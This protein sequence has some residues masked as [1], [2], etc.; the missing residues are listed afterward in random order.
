ML[1][2]EVS[3]F[4]HGITHTLAFPSWATVC[5][6]C[7][8]IAGCFLDP[9]AWGS[10]PCRDFRDNFTGLG[11]WCV[12]ALQEPPWLL[13]PLPPPSLISL[14]WLA[15]FALVMPLS[16]LSHNNYAGI[17]SHYIS[18]G[19]GGFYT[20]GETLPLRGTV[21]LKLLPPAFTRNCSR[22]TSIRPLRVT[23]F[24]TWY[25]WFAALVIFSSH[26]LT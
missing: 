16:K 26:C 18:G 19:G 22:N 25:S 15:F 8:E 17:K 1:P 2:S 5:F 4:A 9:P 6:H 10:F 20:A 24:S 21:P 12:S 7:P 13:P 23:S 14:L 3:S 11:C